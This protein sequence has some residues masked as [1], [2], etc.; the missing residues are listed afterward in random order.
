[1]NREL[2]E[3]AIFEPNE[4]YLKSQQDLTFTIFDLINTS[5]FSTIPLI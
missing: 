4:L 5:L 3:M 1:M 2:L